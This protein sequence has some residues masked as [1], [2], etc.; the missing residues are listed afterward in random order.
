[1]LRLAYRYWRGDLGQ[2]MFAGVL[3]LMAMLI[4]MATVNAVS[5]IQDT[6]YEPAKR[7]LGGNA[8]EVREG[9]N[10]QATRDELNRLWISLTDGSPYQQGDLPSGTWAKTL[11]LPGQAI[12]NQN[13]VSATFVGRSKEFFTP[14]L[15]PNVIRG[16]FLQPT[17]DGKDVALLAQDSELVQRY[18]LAVGSTVKLAI[19]QLRDGKLYLDESESRGFEVVGLYTDILVGGNSIIIPLG[20]LQA[21]ANMEGLIQIAAPAG[22]DQTGVIHDLALRPPAGLK[23]VLPY[24]VL[25]GMT[26]DV[27]SIRRMALVINALVIAVSMACV[28]SS[29]LYLLSL[30]RR[31]LALLLACG[32]PPWGLWAIVALETA[33]VAVIAAFLAVGA[34]STLMKLS[35]GTFYGLRSSLWA[36]AAVS[37]VALAFTV[38]PA[39]TAIRI[40]PMEALR[41]E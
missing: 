24:N 14:G 32:A 15:S 34:Y 5:A 38:P 37:L 30:R 6:M 19:P 41:N 27:D 21:I 25:A 4:Y 29:V 7:F 8:A 39:I 22:A 13:R 35:G 10:V 11:M 23:T 20:T 40:K 18:K 16:R 33:G 17:D 12:V 31:E 9:S 26:R 36:A 3:V 1:M 28:A 2:F